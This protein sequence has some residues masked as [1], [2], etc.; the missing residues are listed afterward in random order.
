MSA[1]DIVLALALLGDAAAS[2]ADTLVTLGNL[3]PGDSTGNSGW[4]FG[5]FYVEDPATGNFQLIPYALSVQF[6]YTLSQPGLL[7]ELSLPIYLVQGRPIA[8]LWVSEVGSGAALA[9][10]MLSAYDNVGRGANGLTTLSRSDSSSCQASYPAT[11]C[12]SD[13]LLQPGHRYSIR[14]GPVLDFSYSNGAQDD[15]RWGWRM[16]S[17]G[18]TGLY[19]ASGLTGSGGYNYPGPTPAWQA[20][21]SVPS[22]VPEPATWGL[23]LAGSGLLAAWRRRPA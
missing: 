8:T 21:V 9:A 1:R 13:T 7:Q 11:T 4:S 3:G 12:F 22:A 6:D 14:L 19:Y 15:S 17:V 5:R 2:Q 23:M 18:E 10:T 20:V 16:N